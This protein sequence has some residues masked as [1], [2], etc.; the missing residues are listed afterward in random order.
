MPNLFREQ[1]V[2]DEKQSALQAVEEGEQVRYSYR[3]RVK[4]ETTKDPH[5]TQHKHLSHSSDEEGPAVGNSTRESHL[6][7]C[8]MCP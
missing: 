2:H 8:A 3:A 6:C 7:F 1:A 4:L 5:G